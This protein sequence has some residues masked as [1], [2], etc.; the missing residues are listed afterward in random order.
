MH[1]K[2]HPSALLE[3]LRGLLRGLVHS[4]GDVAVLLHL[5]GDKVKLL[6]AL[7]YR[8]W[9]GSCCIAKETVGD[10]KTCHKRVLSLTSRPPRLLVVFSCVVSTS[11]LVTLLDLFVRTPC[12]SGQMQRDN[13][14]EGFA[15][16]QQAP[17]AGWTSHSVF[18]TSHTWP[19]GP[20]V[21]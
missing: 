5:Q 11:R 20:P 14:T 13:D 2:T 9:V 21:T 4:V 12:K 1:A 18:H 6:A 15:M 19:L 7:Q 16:V 10:G 8:G 17:T 3:V